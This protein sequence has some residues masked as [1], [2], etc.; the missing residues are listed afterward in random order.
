MDNKGQISAELLLILAIM[1]MIV[2]ITAYYTT[3]YLNEITNHTRIVINN[4]RNSI[5]SKL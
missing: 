4:S 2:L 1:S 3:S 5:L